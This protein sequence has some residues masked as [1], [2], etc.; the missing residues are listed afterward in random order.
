MLEY[1]WF[2]PVA[3][4]RTWVKASNTERTVICRPRV[5]VKSGIRIHTAAS[6]G[7]GSSLTGK[8]VHGHGITPWHE[9]RSTIKPSTNMGMKMKIMVSAH[10]GRPLLSSAAVCESRAVFSAGESDPSPVPLPDEVHRDSR[11]PSPISGVR[12]TPSGSR[13]RTPQGRGQRLN[14]LPFSSGTRHKP[15]QWSVPGKV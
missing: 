5:R 7:G 1:H 14:F 8:A 12:W 4:P 9:S 2:R 10:K 3:R 15:N 11:T 13:N 6:A